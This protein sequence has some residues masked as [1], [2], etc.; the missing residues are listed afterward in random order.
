MKKVLQGGAIISKI[1]YMV[2]LEKKLRTQLA[3]N[4]ENQQK[5]S[6]QLGKLPKGFVFVRKIG[7]QKYVYRKYKENGKVI[8]VYIGNYDDQSVKEEICKIKEYCKIRDKLK[9]LKKIEEETRKALKPY[10]HNPIIKI[11]SISIFDI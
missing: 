2:T 8:S 1:I 11:G 9:E 6:E 5:L 3:S 7:K 4:L 10:E